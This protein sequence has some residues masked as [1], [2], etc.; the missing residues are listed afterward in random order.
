MLVW[1]WRSSA[2]CCPGWAGSGAA[3]RVAGAPRRCRRLAA[4]RGG[5]GRARRRPPDRFR[6]GAARSGGSDEPDLNRRGAQSIGQTLTVVGRSCTAAARSASATRCGPGRAGLPGGHARPRRARGP[7]CWSR[8]GRGAGLH[9]CAIVRGTAACPIREH[10]SSEQRCASSALGVCSSP[11]SCCPILHARGGRAGCER[12]RRGLCQS[13]QQAR[14]GRDRLCSWPRGGTAA[15][16][17]GRVQRFLGALALAG[18]LRQNFQLSR[19]CAAGAGLWCHAQDVRHCAPRPRARPHPARPRAARARQARR[20]GADRVHPR[21]AGVPRQGLPRSA[22]RRGQDAA[23]RHAAAPRSSASSA[24]TG[25]RCWHLGPRDG[26][27]Q[28]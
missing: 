20:E 4:A 24:S 15:R 21:A 1:A 8:I 23:R 11:R 9:R 13:R 5:V 19:A 10:R 12:G 6:V 14:G 3:R 7:C 16:A 2:S 26:V 28:P 27:R 17:D 18:G 22:R 25:T